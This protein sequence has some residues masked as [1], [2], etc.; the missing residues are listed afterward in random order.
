METPRAKPQSTSTSQ[1]HVRVVLKVRPFL[2]SEFKNGETLTPCIFLLDR[3]G[4]EVTVH[5]KDQLTS[6]NEIYKLDSIFGQD[7]L[8][9]QI[10]HKEVFSM[11]T[12]IF[13]GI[14]AT[15]FVYGA[16]GSGKTYTMQ[17]TEIELGLIPLSVAAILSSISGSQ[18]LVEFSYYEVY[19]DRCY[20]LLE[21]K[22]KEIMALDD[23]DGKVQLKGLSWNPGSYQEAAH[24]VSLAARS[25]QVV[26]YVGSAKRKEIPKE[27]VDMEAKLRAWLES[28]GKT[29]NIQRMNVRTPNPISYSKNLRSSCTSVKLKDGESISTSS[30]GR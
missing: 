1:S 3:A 11:I 17:G 7:D 5:I 26:N 12:G 9:S 2:P 28:K 10:F 16:T 14:N 8:I 18:F 22:A 30:K 15:I 21:P 29:R 13:H 24:T 23:K 4:D 27:S 19:L 20:D 25:R 6:R